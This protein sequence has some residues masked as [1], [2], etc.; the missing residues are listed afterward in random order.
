MF[1]SRSIKKVRSVFRRAARPAARSGRRHR[2]PHAALHHRGA[3]LGLWSAS[4]L[5][6]LACR[7]APTP[8]SDDAV[9]Q[10][11]ATRVPAS[12]DTPEVAA[13]TLL[14]GIQEELRALRRNDRRLASAFHEHLRAAVHEAA[15]AERFNKAPH[16][17]L[18]LG[19]GD[20]TDRITGVW[21]ADLA[22]YAE[23]LHFERMRV[24]GGDGSAPV[25]TVLVLVPGSGRDDEAW[26]ELTC[27][28]RSDGTWGVSGIDFASGPP[29]E[30]GAPPPGG[31]ADAPTATESGPA[32]GAP[33]EP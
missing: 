31:A 8:G 32:D 9:R 4:L 15:V 10:E 16:Y 26:I 22:Y 25:D 20:V 18:L 6:V 24:V 27:V 17:R 21:A 23:G 7:P 1:A 33:R 13:R 19:Q 12:V 2:A 28:R 11:A 5:F 14:R 29:A 30:A 3:L